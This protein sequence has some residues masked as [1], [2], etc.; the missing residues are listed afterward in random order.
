MARTITRAFRAEVLKPWDGT[1]SRLSLA[2]DPVLSVPVGSFAYTTDSQ[3]IASEAS[4]L[5]GLSVQDWSDFFVRHGI[6]RSLLSS[7]TSAQVS[8][9]VS[10]VSSLTKMPI[11][12]I[13]LRGNKIHFVRLVLH[14]GTRNV[15]GQTHPV[16]I[17][18]DVRVDTGGWNEYA[19]AV[20]STRL[21]L[22][23]SS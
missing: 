1:V 13:V 5:D 4:R 16:D 7:A 11:G 19:V 14:V 15:L 17:S 23:D 12:P 18:A 20:E 21:D 22:A 9:A 8:D 10:D 2:I 6:P 3:T